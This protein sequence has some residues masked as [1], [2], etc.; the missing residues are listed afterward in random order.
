MTKEEQARARFTVTRRPTDEGE[1]TLIVYRARWSGVWTVSVML[2]LLV[3]FFG[4]VAYC[5]NKATDR[6][7]LLGFCLLVVCFFS[8]VIFRQ[9]LPRLEVRLC[10]GKGGWRRTLFSQGKWT[11]FAYGKGTVVQE[12]LAPKVIGSPQMVRA[13]VVVPKE[14]SKNFVIAHQMRQEDAD[15]FEE[16]FFATFPPEWCEEE[17]PHEETPVEAA[18]R[19]TYEA[20]R[21]R[22]NSPFLKIARFASVLVAVA[23]LR[24][25]SD[26]YFGRQKVRQKHADAALRVFAQHGDMATVLK[27]FDDRPWN[28]G[29]KYR[30]EVNRFKA[31]LVECRKLIDLSL[32]A[33]DG[34]PSGAFALNGI[35]RTA[36]SRVKD[37]RAGKDRMSGTI[38]VQPLTDMYEQ[39]LEFTNLKPGNE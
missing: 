15:V 36:E 28:Y 6:W 21:K 23:A 1:E 17:V 38:F 10:G 22:A 2:V 4:W 25:G 24:V 33:N 26:F 11:P 7:M 14:G 8:Y 35:R 5:T 32:G 30:D 9:L 27:M 37:L 34:S 31:E 39:L 16:H 20:A 18:I 12:E 19:R 3:S 29:R 13:L